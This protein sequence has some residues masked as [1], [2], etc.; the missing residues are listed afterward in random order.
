MFEN[1]RSRES[2][3]FLLS[4]NYVN[5]VICLR[6]DFTND[7]ILAY[8]IYLLRTLSF[9]LSKDT[10]YF[11]FNEHLD[12]FPL[13]SEAIKFFNH[14]ESM[15]RIAVRVI[16]LNVY[17]V[18]DSQMQDFILDRTTTTYFSNLVWFIGNYGTTVN[19][20]LLHPGE[21]EFSRMNYY[22]AEHMDC[23][24]YVNDIIELDVSKINKIL[25]S[26][27]L[28]RLLRPMYLDSLLSPS[29]VSSTGNK[30]SSASKLTPVV[31]LSLMLH[32][33]HV[34]KYA[35][36]V[37]ALAS[38]L[39]SS[40]LYSSQAPSQHQHQQ[41]QQQQQQH[42]H[43]RLLRPS[44]ILLG[45]QSGSPESSRPASP[46][47]SKFHS[48]GLLGTSPGFESHMSPS[49][50]SAPFAHQS[51]Q[52]S[53][54]P[55]RTHS[56]HLGQ[57]TVQQQQQQNPYKTSIYEY[58]G[59]VDNDRL[60]LPVLALIYLAGRNPGIMSDVLLGTDIYPHRLLKS[61]L[62]MGNLISS[63]PSAKQETTAMTRERSVDSLLSNHS[64]SHSW[65]IPTS[66][67]TIPSAITGSL[68]GAAGT[69]AAARMRTRT[70]SPL[71]ETDEDNAESR[72]TQELL[73]S[74]LQH[75]AERPNSSPADPPPHTSA[76]ALSTSLPSPA[77]SMNR[78]INGDG[79]GRYK[80]RTRGRRNSKASS[81]VGLVLPP[82]SSEPANIIDEEEDEESLGQELKPVFTSKKDRKPARDYPST[83]EEEG[84]E[85]ENGEDDMPQLDNGVQ[86]RDSESSPPPLPPRPA[87][88][89]QSETT[90]I[91]GSVRTTH[92]G[93][94][95]QN[96]EDLMDRL[97]DIVCGQ[98]ESGA[99]RFR[100]LTIQVATELLIEFV[101][102][103]GVPGKET[104]QSS[105]STHAATAA[106]VESQLGQARLHRLALAE[107]QFRERVQ[108]GIRNL[109]KRNKSAELTPIGLGLTN[110]P[111]GILTGR[112]ERAITE[113]KLGIDKQIVN[114]ISDSNIIYGPDR[115]LDNEPDLD[116]DPDLVA[117]FSLDPEYTSMI[118]EDLSTGEDDK[119]HKDKDIDRPPTSNSSAGSAPSNRMGKRD[120]IRNTFKAKIHHGASSAPSSPLA[121]HGR[122][123]PRLSQ[124]DKHA[125]KLEAMVVRYIKW[126][127]MLIQCRQLLCWKTAPSAGGT[128]ESASSH[129]SSG[130]VSA[131]STPRPIPIQRQPSDLM[132]DASATSS[133]STTSSAGA[134][135]SAHKGLQK[136]LATTATTTPMTEHVVDPKSSSS[137]TTTTTSLLPVS[138][139]SMT[140]NSA[141]LSTSPSASSSTSS[142]SLSRSSMTTQT[143]AVSAMLSQPGTGTASGRIIGSRTLLTA[144]AALEAAAASSAAATGSSMHH[145][146]QGVGVSAVI[147][148]FVN[149]MLT[150]HL[151]PLSASVSEAIRKSSAQFR[152]SVVDPISTNPLFN[153]TSLASSSS[154]MSASSAGSSSL[155]IGRDLIGGNNSGNGSANCSSKGGLYRPS[156][157]QRS[158]SECSPSTFQS[159]SIGPDAT[160][161]CSRN[162]AS[163]EGFEAA[164][165]E[166]D[167]VDEDEKKAEKEKE[168]KSI[169][170][171][172][173]PAHQTDEHVARI[174]ETLGLL[175]SARFTHDES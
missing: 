14:E 126:L 22:L 21:G 107:M 158:V 128:V 11:F 34:L 141:V 41:Y 81:L 103:K 93:P 133:T 2:L 153:K 140:T 143:P 26:H 95:I 47:T 69:A 51:P 44:P 118:H 108:K 99:H 91:H 152:K 117:L 132:R 54:V 146:H 101:Y 160:F 16:T 100:I 71:F 151:D 13:Y 72:E 9:K 36:L 169:L 31:A 43:Y 106:A 73:A 23:F 97:V 129:P 57:S 77:S 161:S 116:P 78:V 109:E 80:I 162:A 66:A 159:G 42:H 15:I 147:P 148:P 123:T 38:T 35:P 88:D 46:V 3:Y 40:Q 142:L 156:N 76:K 6:Y 84:E 92:L 85:E 167:K 19:D 4:N 111:L 70:E 20:M 37:S 127:H 45:A 33:F 122:Q 68:F 130:S 18:N 55:P 24:Y 74:E 134:V 136:A 171:P 119:L 105:S 102:T 5:Q 10:I 30:S 112:V 1:V 175:D 79:P 165:E 150:T 138:S 63:A 104:S 113:S 94:V 32:A 29:T 163:V 87:L 173:H 52:Q 137:T 86:G 170:D 12:D 98:P 56:P 8:Y 75:P 154:S 135:V 82:T 157:R 28:N 59:H 168:F 90:S 125:R 164:E 121:S 53:L 39:F 166:K 27:L 25:I 58:L 139:P 120:R 83:D 61:R 67:H 172:G 48:F 144:T 60:V 64:D 7:E 114:M 124:K 145:N 62:L 174:L 49:T 17:S 115:D 110:Q 155:A 65:N 96:R 89:S 50:T 131:T 149:E